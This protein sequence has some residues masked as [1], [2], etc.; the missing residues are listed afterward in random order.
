L[1][2]FGVPGVAIY[3]WMI[4][5]VF[6]LAHTEDTWHFVTVIALFAPFMLD[7]FMLLR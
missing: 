7:S 3:C 5:I 1:L 2:W 4:P 6:G